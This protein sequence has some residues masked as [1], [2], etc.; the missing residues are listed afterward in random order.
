MYKTVLITLKTIIVLAFI[1]LICVLVYYFH[2]NSLNQELLKCQI[3]NNTISYAYK[4]N[5]LKFDKNTKKISYKYYTNN[6]FKTKRFAINDVKLKAGM[7][8]IIA[9][10]TYSYKYLNQSFFNQPNSHKRNVAF[11][12]IN[13][14]I[15]EE[16]LF[17]QKIVFNNTVE[18]Y[19]KD[20]LTIYASKKQ[21][22]KINDIN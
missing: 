12:L 10:R 16:H 17:P 5:S 13:K 15:S 3:Q 2:L 9:T 8:K 20:K 21:I 11:Q 14:Y 1:S 18:L 19:S 6:G 22:S 4:E 7:P